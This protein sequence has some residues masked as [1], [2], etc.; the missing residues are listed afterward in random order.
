[1]QIGDALNGLDELAPGIRGYTIEI[2]N[3]VYV[4][5]VESLEPG[6][7]HFRAYLDTLKAMGRTIKFPTVISVR[8]RNILEVAGFEL[9]WEWSKDFQELVDVWRWPPAG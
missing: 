5:F 9:I 8:L 2:G 1:M 4:P 6:K 3:D 7:G